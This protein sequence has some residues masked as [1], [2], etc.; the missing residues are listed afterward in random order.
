M[1]HPNLA[2]LLSY[3]L[4]QYLTS[5]AKPSLQLGAVA[6]FTV[7]EMASSTAQVHA[8]AAVAHFTSPN[9]TTNHPNRTLFLGLKL[10]SKARSNSISRCKSTPRLVAE[11]IVGIDLETTNSAV[12]PIVI[13]AQVYVYLVHFVVSVFHFFFFGCEFCFGYYLFV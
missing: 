12:A 5:N 2:L 13:S 10:K 8:L 3:L 4:H 7:R 6:H 1:S 9:S 11:K